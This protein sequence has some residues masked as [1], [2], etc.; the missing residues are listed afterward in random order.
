LNFLQTLD[1][2][3]LDD[4]VDDDNDDDVLLQQTFSINHYYRSTQLVMFCAGF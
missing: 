2:L 1:S 4:Y 3:A